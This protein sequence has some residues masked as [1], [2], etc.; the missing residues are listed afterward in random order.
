MIKL[1]QLN[2][3]LQQNNYLREK[4]IDDKVFYSCKENKMNDIIVVVNK[5]K[6]P[7]RILIEL[8][9]IFDNGWSDSATSR[10][11]EELDATYPIVIDFIDIKIIEE[12]NKVIIETT[13]YQERKEA[14]NFS[15]NKNKHVIEYNDTK[16]NYW[17]DE[18][19]TMNPFPNVKDIIN[20]EINKM[21]KP[22]RE[23]KYLEGTKVMYD[24]Y[25]NGNSYRYDVFKYIAIRLANKALTP[26]F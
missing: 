26:H 18:F 7:I 22:N 20:E 4:V 21:G 17:S 10:V 8:Y 5:D 14:Y 24:Y 19:K 15:T 23:L 9:I 25:N 2:Q 6:Q 12:T 11:I 16:G 1:F 3:L 13:G